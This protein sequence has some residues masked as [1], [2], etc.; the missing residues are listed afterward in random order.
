MNWCSLLLAIAALMPGTTNA[1][2]APQHL[3]RKMGSVVGRQRERPHLPKPARM[4]LFGSWT[5]KPDSAK[6]E[7]PPPQPKGGMGMMDQVKQMQEMQRR[8][9]KLQDDLQSARVEATAAVGGVTIVL[10]GMAAPVSVTITDECMATGSAVVGAGLTE[11]LKAA[12][13][14][15]RA[16]MEQKTREI[17]E[18]L[19]MGAMMGGIKM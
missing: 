17:Y 16:L 13:A 2:L 8:A 3:V 7:E 14:D 9:K 1:F 15:C 19:D 4:G 18:G 12:T 5:A 11:A 10:N 6:R